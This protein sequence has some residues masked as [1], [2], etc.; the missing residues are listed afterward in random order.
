MAVVNQFN[1]VV[2][3]ER[4][5]VYGRHMIHMGILNGI[6]VNKAGEMSLATAQM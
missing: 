2:R 6:N 4:K 5:I 3:D 1:T